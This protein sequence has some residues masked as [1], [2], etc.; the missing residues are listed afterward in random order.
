MI[1]EKQILV[2]FIILI[3]SISIL[4]QAGSLPDTG[5]TKCYDDQG[6]G[7]EITCP[8]SG[9]AFYGQ[10]AQYTT[11]P[12]SYTKLDSQGNDLPDSANEWTMVR[13][14]VTELVWEVKINQNGLTDYAN[15]NDADNTYT[16]YDSNPDTNGGNA[17]TYSVATDTE[18]YINDL[19]LMQFGG[20]SDWRLPTAKEIGMFFIRYKGPNDWPF[21]DTNYFP[22]VKLDQSHN[23]MYWSSTTDAD[24]ITQGWAFDFADYDGMFSQEKS[25]MYYVRAVRG[26]GIQENNFYDNGDGTIDDL[27]TGLTWQQDSLPYNWQG[28]LAYCENLTLAQHSDWRLP[29][30]Y[31]LLTLLDHNK[32][33]LA[34]NSDFYSSTAATSYW[35]STS[36]HLTLRAWVVSFDSGRIKAE[37][38]QG[39]YYVRA[40]RGGQYIQ[41]ILPV[42]N[43]GSD[44][45]AFISVALDGS[46]ST[47]ADGT[48]ISWEWTLIH[49]TNVSYNKTATGSNPTI[50][51][52]SAGFY[53]VELTVTDNSGDTDTDT[54]LLGV[55]GPW[56]VNGDG[57][58]GLEEAIHALQVVSGVRSE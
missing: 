29:N 8:Q 43:A 2:P 32:A 22:N 49:R 58:I 51:N 57:K 37:D 54:M 5:Q 23:S 48:I 15:P 36:I 21:I 16:W 12:P 38:K 34:I 41:N 26:L 3:L 50:T 24:A 40:V 1:K 14:N 45:T 47:D 42:A 52:L 55:A 19:N 10:D 28:A 4:A 33:D 31:E 25:K 46:S 44:K 6:V 11:N 30:I 39:N 17:G 56:D 7:T 27:N 20:F 9:E 13:D 18:D 35:S 53:D